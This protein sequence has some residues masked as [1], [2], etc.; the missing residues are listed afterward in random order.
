[1]KQS[2]KTSIHGD[3][4]GAC[5]VLCVRQLFEGNTHYDTPE[6][7]RFEETVAQLVRFYPER[8]SP[9]GIGMRVEVLGC[10]LPGTY[11]RVCVCVCLC[12][13]VTQV[14]LAV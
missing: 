3:G 10:D 9:A 13:C 6:L 5:C 4:N 14:A 1:M 12:V 11:Q 2:F 8:W 7:R